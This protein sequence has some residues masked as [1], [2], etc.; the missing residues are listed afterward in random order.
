MYSLVRWHIKTSLIF[1]GLGLL[2]GMYMVAGQRLGGGAVTPGHITAHTHVLLVGFMLTLVMGVAL[3]MFPRP[4]KGTDTHY[5]PTVALVTYILITSATILRF[6]GELVGA[7][8]P[9]RLWDWLVIVGGVGQTVAGILFIVNIWTR[10]RPAG[11][12]A[13]EAAGERF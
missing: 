3:W 2:L 10:I 1:L 7:Y 6:V 12:R 5:K 8:G 11:S 9:G 4:S 13:R